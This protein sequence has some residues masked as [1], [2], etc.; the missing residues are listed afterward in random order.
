[1]KSPSGCSG[2]SNTGVY[3]AGFATNQEDYDQ[4]LRALKVT[5]GI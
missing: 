1:M 2:I 5:K 3:K 4:K